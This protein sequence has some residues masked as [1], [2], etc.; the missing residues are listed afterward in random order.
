MTVF[1]FD[2]IVRFLFLAV[3]VL[4]FKLAWEFGIFR[5]EV[6]GLQL[7]LSR[8]FGAISW[9]GL[10]VFMGGAFRI[11]AHQTNFPSMMDSVETVIIR[12]LTVLP[13]LVTLYGLAKF[14]N[15]QNDL[16]ISK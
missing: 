12:L 2:L 7:H 10:G 11:F 14:L 1:I 5:K 8:V 9:A 13:L 15:R 6:K 3:F 16:T 4:G